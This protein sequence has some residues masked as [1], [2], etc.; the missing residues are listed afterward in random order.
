MLFIFK[1]FNQFVTLITCCLFRF[2]LKLIEKNSIRLDNYKKLFDTFYPSLCIFSSKYTNNL[3]SS[4]DLVQEVFIKIWNDKLLL[5]EDDNVK[6]Y[7]Y[8]MVRNKSLDF[9]KSKEVRNKTSLDSEILNLITSQSY[10]EKH[11]LIEETSR[12]VNEAVNTLP[13]K[14]KR[15]INLSLKGHG[16]KQISEEL[17]ISLNTVKTQKRIAYQKLRPLLKGAFLLLL[18][19]LI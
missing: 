9:I 14:C 13:Y 2:I 11:V 1:N 7:L 10:F 5:N 16:N 3:E 12:L 6:A 8:T 18:Y 15:I 4:K 17:S 19:F